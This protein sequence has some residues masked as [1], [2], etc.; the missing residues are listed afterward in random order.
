MLDA[1]LS[2]DILHALLYDDLHGNVCCINYLIPQLAVIARPV[3]EKNGR[4]VV[5]GIIEAGV[6]GQPEFT[7]RPK[8]DGVTADWLKIQFDCALE[9][10]NTCTTIISD[11]R[12][13]KYFNK[14]DFPANFHKDDSIKIKCQRKIMDCTLFFKASLMIL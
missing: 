4:N 8:K 11:V 13:P 3:Y 2:V 7:G 9:C 14:T 6:S 5:G 10:P 1:E 12:G